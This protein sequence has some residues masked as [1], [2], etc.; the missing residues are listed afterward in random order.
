MNDFT[1]NAYPEFIQVLADLRAAHSDS[2]GPRDDRNSVDRILDILFEM[3]RRY[4]E[5]E[6]V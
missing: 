3:K 4:E 1:T 6:E 2:R 5:Q